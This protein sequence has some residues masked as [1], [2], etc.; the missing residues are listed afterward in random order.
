MTGVRVV[1]GVSTV[2]SQGRSCLILQGSQRM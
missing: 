2:L 1:T